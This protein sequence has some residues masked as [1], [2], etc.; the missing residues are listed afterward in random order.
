MKLASSKLAD[1]DVAVH[2]FVTRF[3]LTIDDQMA[4]LPSVEIDGEDAADVAAKWVDENEDVW[5][6]WLEPGPAPLDT[7]AE[8]T[9]ATTGA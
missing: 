8:S 2:D 1:K 6:A 4:M 3:T 5:S 9:P 7:T